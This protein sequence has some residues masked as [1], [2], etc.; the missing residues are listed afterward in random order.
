M[1]VEE[2]SDR[3]KLV[4]QLERTLDVGPVGGAKA[5]RVLSL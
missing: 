5:C 3:S 4:P 2:R 1:E